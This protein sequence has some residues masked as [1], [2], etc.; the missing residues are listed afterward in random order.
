MLFNCGII[1]LSNWLIIALWITL[2]FFVIAS[3]REITVMV[4]QMKPFAYYE[5]NSFKGIEIDILE[6]FGKRFKLNIK[7]LEANE[8]LNEIFSNHNQTKHFL[9]SVNSS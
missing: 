8:T 5:E 2:S 7:Y 6:N 1:L 3:A 9:K 4:S